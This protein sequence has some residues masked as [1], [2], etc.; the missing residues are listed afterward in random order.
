MKCQ[1]MTKQQKTD[2]FHLLLLNLD[3]WANCVTVY[4]KYSG[5]FST[6]GL[7]L[8]IQ[9]RRIHFILFNM[10]PVTKGYGSNKLHEKTKTEIVC[11]SV[12]QYFLPVMSFSQSQF[13]PTRCKSLKPSVF[14]LLQG[15]SRKQSD[16]PQLFL[17]VCR[18]KLLFSFIHGIYK[19][20]RIP[21]DTSFYM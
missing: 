18:I 21:S 19:K 1:E 17:L 10:S 11:K 9:P 2:S 6:K 16:K 20:L 7:T 5:H 8:G 4:L 13:S 14:S 15:G 3:H 12:S